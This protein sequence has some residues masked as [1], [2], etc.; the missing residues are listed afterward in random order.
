MWECDYSREPVDYRLYFLR[1]LKKIWLLPVAVILG[2]AICGGVYCFTN[3]V[4]QGGHEY[5]A[6]TKYYVT[7]AKDDVGKEYDYY[8]YATWQE[9]IATD[10]FTDGI[11]SRMGGAVTA[12]YVREKV[13]ARIETDYRYLYSKSVSRDKQQAVDLEKAVSELILKLPEMKAEIESIEVIDKASI[14]KL[15]DISLIFEKHAFIV[16]AFV[17]LIAFFVFSV[18]YYG[19]STA[20]YIPATLEK[21][22]HFPVLGAPSMAEFEENCKHILGKGSRL[23][24]VF[25]DDN[26]SEKATAEQAER[27]TF[28]GELSS[29]M[30][31]AHQPE[32]A[33]KIRACD[34]VVV[35]VKAGRHNGRQTQRCIEQLSRQ[36]IKITAM[37]LYGEDERLIKAYYRR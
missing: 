18:F 23:A 17:G 35:A 12:Q 6:Q 33:D 15:E 4:I 36:D 28:S 21:R 30:S 11:V 13:T 31:P 25:A 7:F 20:V 37:Y 8:N 29:F 24:V 34:A 5:R 9:L 32:S 2:A 10:F 3:Y 1:L 26:I 19:A 22:Y 27:I 14:D 16:G